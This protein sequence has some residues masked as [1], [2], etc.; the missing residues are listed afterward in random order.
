MSQEAQPGQP[1]LGAKVLVRFT[2]PPWPP[3]ALGDDTADSLVGGGSS[4]PFVS[5]DEGSIVPPTLL[6]SHSGLSAWCALCDVAGIAESAGRSLS[7]F[8]N[9]WSLGLPTTWSSL[10][11]LSQQQLQA[12]GPAAAGDAEPDACP[13]GGLLHIRPFSVRGAGLQSPQGRALPPGS[14]KAVWI[15]WCLSFGNLPL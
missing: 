11:D 10:P 13:W 2:C 9:R 1:E 15:F 7:R 6:R 8:A 3:L 4:G 5:S 14:N 12:P